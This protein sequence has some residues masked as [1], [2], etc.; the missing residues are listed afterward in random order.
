M[1]TYLPTPLQLT[2]MAMTTPCPTYPG[3]PI[4]LLFYTSQSEPTV[5]S[6]TGRTHPS[7]EP[8]IHTYL[9]QLNY[10]LTDRSTSRG[11]MHI[12]IHIHMHLRLDLHTWI[13]QGVVRG[14]QSSQ[15]RQLITR[16]QRLPNRTRLQE[17]GRKRGAKGKTL[18]CVY[19]VNISRNYN[20][21]T[22]NRGE[23]EY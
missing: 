20:K 15:T 23:K 3:R 18:A 22:P 7:L 9:Q 10:L 11:H 13:I 16:N 17:A 12:H 4:Y 1:H 19:P 21:D 2:G 14:N 8:Y 6:P 5:K